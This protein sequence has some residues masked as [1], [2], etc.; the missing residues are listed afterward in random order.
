MAPKPQFV[1]YVWIGFMDGYGF[2]V[3][4]PEIHN[5][6]S[7][8]NGRKTICLWIREKKSWEY[9]DI[10]ESR[11]ELRANITRTTKADRD[12]ISE[13]YWEWKCESAGS[14]G[15]TRLTYGSI[16]D[17]VEHAVEVVRQEDEAWLGRLGVIHQGGNP[18]KKS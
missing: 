18:N 17:S 15:G 4:D 14:N 10:E 1:K 7:N 12:R 8:E 2:I 5:L 6:Y 16:H 11:R 3:F 9:F 13:E